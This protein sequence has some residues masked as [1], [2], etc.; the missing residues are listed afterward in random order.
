MYLNTSKELN[1][2]SSMRGI[3]IMAEEMLHSIEPRDCYIVLQHISPKDHDAMKTNLAQIGRELGISRERVRQLLKRGLSGLEAGEHLGPLTELVNSNESCHSELCRLMEFQLKKPISGV[4]FTSLTTISYIQII[5]LITK[6]DNTLLRSNIL[7]EYAS[8]LDFNNNIKMQNIAK[9]ELNSTLKLLSKFD[10]PPNTNTRMLLINKRERNY[11]TKHQISSLYDLLQ[12]IILQQLE[13]EKCH[14]GKVLS[15]L[16]K[17]LDALKQGDLTTIRKYLPLAQSGIGLSFSVYVQFAILK[18][19]PVV[20]KAIHLYFKDALPIADIARKCNRSEVRISQIV[21][22]TR[23]EIDR[24]LELFPTER[25][26]LWSAWERCEPI[27]ELL[28]NGELEYNMLHVVAGIIM[29]TIVMSKE[30]QAIMKH[31]AEIFSKW[32]QELLDN[33]LSISSSTSIP[34]FLRRKRKRD[35][36]QCFMEYLLDRSCLLVNKTTGIVTLYD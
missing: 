15:R 13:S 19:I 1:P 22:R 17:L 18:K 23:Q 36:L 7:E 26:K 9:Q 3:W 4:R 25:R 6:I 21:Q 20:Q 32:M 10:I 35:L 33:E 31:R 12:Y 27:I 24:I 8:S 5:L 16:S 2:I 14:T 30:G 11:L 29:K 28:D 34:G